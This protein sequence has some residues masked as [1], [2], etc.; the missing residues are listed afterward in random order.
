MDLNWDGYQ[1]QTI[2]T[3]V[4]GKF[5][6]PI[7]TLLQVS[8]LIRTSYKG[9][10]STIDLIAELKSHPL[11]IQTATA[12]ISSHE[13]SDPE[14]IVLYRKALQ[15]LKGK[16]GDGFCEDTQAEFAAAE[17]SIQKLSYEHHH[18][19]L[20]CSFLDGMS[21]PLELLCRLHNYSHACECHTFIQSSFSCIRR[22]SKR[23]LML[24]SYSNRSMGHQ[25]PSV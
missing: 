3:P 12:Y 9:D 4:S 8:K 15:D 2:D 20:L 19:L 13:I 1:T 22:F 17:V 5:P 11:A 24:R 7:V 16:L 23:L 25:T 14:Y 6:S 21:I 10:S 18:L